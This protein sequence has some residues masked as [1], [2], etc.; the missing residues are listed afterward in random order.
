MNRTFVVLA[1]LLAVA[2]TGCGGSDAEFEIAS[3]DA[4]A[5]NVSAA[6]VPLYIPPEYA[7]RPEPTQS[8][9]AARPAPRVGLSNGENSLLAMAGAGNANPRIRTLVDQESSSYAVVD[10]FRIERLVLGTA[11]PPPPGFV[12]MRTGSVVIDDPMALF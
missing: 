12:T 2:A 6:Q 5:A 9:Q 10:P 11:D 4:A 7:V 3:R 8:R 1:A